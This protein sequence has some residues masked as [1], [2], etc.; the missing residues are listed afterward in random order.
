MKK[1]FMSLVLAFALSAAAN[2]YNYLT[3][4]SDAVESSVALTQLKKITFS[5]TDLVVTS[6]DG[7]ETRTSLSTLKSL[8][9]SDE[10]TAVRTVRQDGLSFRNGHIVANGQ[11]VLSVYNANGSLVRQQSVSSS[12]SEVNIATLPAG[13]YIVRLGNQTI[14]IAK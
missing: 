12:R 4:A 1:L 2:A 10:P 6:I 3:I 8:Y 5:G 14:K 7:T 11:G 13:I 9:F